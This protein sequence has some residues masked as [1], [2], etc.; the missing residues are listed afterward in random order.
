M[1]TIVITSVTPNSNKFRASLA[2]AGTV[3][4]VAAKCS[5]P[6]RLIAGKNTAD[7]QTFLAQAL[8]ASTIVAVPAPV[9]PISIPAGLTG[10]VLL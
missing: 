4:G 6:Y 9:V 10:T 2:V 1:N 7:A 8:L 3:N 5:V